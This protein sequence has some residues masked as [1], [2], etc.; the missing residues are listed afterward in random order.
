MMVGD[1]HE[2]IYSDQERADAMATAREMLNSY[3]A[4]PA[5]GR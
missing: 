4:S 5:N 1:D 3:L 2:P